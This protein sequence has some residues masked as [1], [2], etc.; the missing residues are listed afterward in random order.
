MDTKITGADNGRGTAVLW[1]F[2]VLYDLTQKYGK[3][4]VWHVFN[5]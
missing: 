5:T 2:M 4:C 3:G 1:W